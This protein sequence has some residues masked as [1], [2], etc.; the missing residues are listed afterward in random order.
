[1]EIPEAEVLR[2]AQQALADRGLP[3][4]EPHTLRKGWRRWMVSSPSNIRGGNATVF[5]HRRTGEAKVRY[6]DR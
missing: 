6:Y 2:I 4:R 1:M 3:W 5:V